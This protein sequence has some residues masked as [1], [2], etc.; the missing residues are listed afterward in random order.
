[1]N[2][3][4]FSCN[5]YDSRLNTNNHQN[6]QNQP[7]IKQRI[8]GAWRIIDGRDGNAWFVIKGDTI[9]FSEPI[10]LALRYK[11]HGDTLVWNIPIVKD[12]SNV[13]MYKILKIYNDTLII[14]N[15]FDKN[16]IYYL[17]KI[18]EN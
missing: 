8:Q 17:H 12:S 16:I 2:L 10:G 13:E 7:T 1:M 18:S 6:I 14:R 5:N 4:I 3:L 11:L 15:P 9:I